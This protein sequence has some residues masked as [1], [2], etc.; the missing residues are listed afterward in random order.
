[1]LMVFCVPTNAVALV[2]QR[3]ANTDTSYPGVVSLLISGVKDAT[4]RL[5]IR[6]VLQAWSD[7]VAHRIERRNIISA[8][9]NIH[10]TFYEEF[11]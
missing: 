4:R 6:R 3:A 2:A 8:E 7:G 10:G 5:P 1:M 11:R 9:W